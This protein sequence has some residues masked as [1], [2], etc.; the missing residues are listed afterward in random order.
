M[1]GGAGG[2]L[3]FMLNNVEALGKPVRASSGSG[4]MAAF[5][6]LTLVAVTTVALKAQE[7]PKL[8]RTS[9]RPMLAVGSRDAEGP[10]LFGSV[11]GALRL[12]SG[13]VVVADRKSL[14]L[15]FFSAAGK[16]L[17]TVGR[18]GSGPGEFRSIVA[19]RRCAGDS[20]FVYDGSIFRLSVFSPDGEYVR[21]ADIQKWSPQGRPNGFWCH[22]SGLGAFIYRLAATP[23]GE[24]P[25]RLNV[26]VTVVTPNDSVVALGQFPATEMYFKASAAGPRHLG[27]ETAIAVGAS[28]V[29]IGTGDAY[30]VARWSLSGRRSGVIREERKPIP[31]TAGQVTTYIKEYIAARDDREDTS[32]HEQ[33]LRSFEYPKTYPAYRGLIVDELDNL[34]I[35][36][37]PVPGMDIREWL[38]YS[39]EG[40]KIARIRLPQGFRLLEAGRDYVLGIWRDDVDVDYVQMYALL[41]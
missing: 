38:V 27:K 36:E 1:R 25:L 40:V 26:D 39:R 24:G 19:L 22:S 7:A 2:C 13:V 28:S 12:K 9:D 15:R 30:E 4:T 29:Y 37:Y 21:A 31:L 16:H 3:I 35:E 10:E 5:V 17:R 8:W 33:Y 32:G 41:K 6:V 11:G 20:L 34:W 18:K 14:D 23:K